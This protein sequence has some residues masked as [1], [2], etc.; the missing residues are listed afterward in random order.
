MEE[1]YRMQ[2]AQTD[3]HQVV[4]NTNPNGKH[5][6]TDSSESAGIVIH[7]DGT[8]VLPRAQRDSLKSGGTTLAADDDDD[9]AST[10]GMSSP[11]SPDSPSDSSGS[12]V[13][14]SIRISTS[15][16]GDLPGQKGEGDEVNGKPN[17]FTE[18]ADALGKPTPMRS[19]D[20]EQGDDP[21]SPI[22]PSQEPFSFS[23]K[24]LCERWLDNLFMV[25]YEVCDPLITFSCPWIVMANPIG[26][27]GSTSMDH[28]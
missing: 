5:V 20:A 15:S 3:I 21:V 6:G 9:D 17:G 4:A 2:K 12:P 23:N 19:G 7:E 13:I 26:C 24:R 16:D 18:K 11:H 22:S 14:P 8:A 25:L 28:I 10:R 27:T 1:E